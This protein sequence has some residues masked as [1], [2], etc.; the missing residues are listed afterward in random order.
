M[1]SE[2]QDPQYPR[3]FSKY[4]AQF[5]DRAQP[6]DVLKPIIPDL[7]TLCSPI[8]VIGHPTIGLYIDGA[9]PGN[10]TP[11]AK[12][13]IG[14]YFGPNSPYNISKA[15]PGH[16]Q[17]SQRAELLAAAAAFQ[18][19]LQVVLQNAGLE[20]FIV[21]TDSA[22]L[23]DGLSKYVYRWKMNG[24]K[25]AKGKD[26]A[27]RDLIEPLDKMLDDMSN[28]GIDVLFWKVDRSENVE[29]DQLA[30]MAVQ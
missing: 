27:N 23:V 21:V 30:N 11:S 20:L 8:V 6:K 25:T 22:Y 18:Q 5:T 28:K 1:T 13:G 12:G 14:A 3:L 4:K 16:N 7:L 10:G 19:I 15:L 24:W 29:A 26:V 17:T 9:C 2:F